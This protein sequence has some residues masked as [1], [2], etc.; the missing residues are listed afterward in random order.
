MFTE[1]QEAAVINLLFF[2]PNNTIRLRDSK[3]HHKGQYNFAQH[4]ASQP[5]HIGLF[6]PW[7]PSAHEADLQGGFWGNFGKKQK[8]AW[9]SELRVFS[10]V[11]ESH[12]ARRVSLSWANICG[13]GRFQLATCKNK[14]LQKEYHQTC[15]VITL[16]ISK[17]GVLHHHAIIGP[18]HTAYIIPF[19]DTLQN[20]LIPNDQG[21]EQPMYT[22]SSWTML[23]WTYFCPQ[24][25][26]RLP[27]FHH[28]QSPPLVSVLESFWR[29][30]LC[31]GLECIWAKALPQAMEVACGD[32]DVGSWQAWMRHSRRYFNAASLETTP[33]VMRV[34]CC[35]SR[36]TTEER[37]SF[38]FLW[39]NVPLHLCW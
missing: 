15:A 3:Q 36:A 30:L 7:R 17:N 34:R 21:P 26:H 6:T 12:G 2:F 16:A 38:H 27:T 31:I 9:D 10:P 14:G 19:P 13:K 39:A 35:W 8:S 23:D 1:A 24:L 25:V 11:T 28:T 32:T 20:R 4:L 37:F 22:F 5:V 33:H 18:N 29:T